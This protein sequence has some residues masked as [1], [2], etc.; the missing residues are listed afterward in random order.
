M[1]KPN[2][3]EELKIAFEKYLKECSKVSSCCGAKT[4]EP[5]KDNLAKCLDC[6]EGCVAEFEIMF[7][8]WL[9]ETN[10]Q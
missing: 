4:T 2:K 10:N 8:D 9:I 6:K 7:Q 1:S 3:N 5:D